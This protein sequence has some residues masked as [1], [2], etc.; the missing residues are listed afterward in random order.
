MEYRKLIETDFNGETF[1]FRYG[2]I[3]RHVIAHEIHHIGQL[4]VWSREIGRKP[5]T[6]NLI[7]RGLFN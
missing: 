5:V 6:A 2:E 7:D 3:M 4:S 1:S